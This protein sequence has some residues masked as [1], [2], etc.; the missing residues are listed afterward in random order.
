MLALSS[1]SLAVFVVLAIL[2]GIVAWVFVLARDSRRAAKQE[3]QRQTRML[4][5]D[6][7]AC[8]LAG[9]ELRRAKEVA[10]AAN[11]AKTR[12]LV[13]LSHEI[14]S[15]LNAI[16]GYA[17]LLER[18]SA[19]PATEAGSVIRRSAEHLT[20]LVDGLLEISRI[21][22][23]V[24]KL[25]S[26]VV[27]LQALLDHVVDMFRMQAAAKGLT[28]NYVVNGRLPRFV[29]TDEKRL[30]QIL[31]NLLSNAIKYTREGSATLSISYRSQMAEVDVVDTGI[32]IEPEDLERIFEPFERGNSPEAMSQPG[33]GLG[34]AITR[35]LARILGGEIF[36]SSAPG[37]GSHFR[38]RIFLPEP[39][40]APSGTAQYSRVIGYDGPRK[41]ILV[42]DDDPAQVTLLQS[43]L[44][45]LD[46]VVYWASQGVEGMMLADRCTP[47][48]VMLDIQIPGMS[49]W[50]VATRL[51]AMHGDALRI[52]MVSA[53][54]HEFRAGG[55][56][57]ASHDAF[58]SKPVD[59]K[60]LL[61]VIGRQLRL[62][63]QVAGENP[64]ADETPTIAPLPE[65]A[66]PFVERLRQQAKVGHVQAVEATLAEL[67]TEVPASISAVVAMR[68]HVRNF[69]LRSL[70]K[71]LDDVQAR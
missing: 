16:Y 17:Q 13:G 51:R 7:A 34:L 28:L 4:Q 29:R 59:F 53:N 40:T 30:R 20:N 54:A 19:I 68:A 47:D 21:E 26:D 62:T 44:R 6:I 38:L 66:A 43:L 37:V 35:V 60:A 18:E 24:T 45:P 10:E 9:A 70:M 12:Y 3:S 48:L 31:I 57:Y 56:E 36:A 52:V 2:A 8:T 33:I 23:G 22:S 42:V 15:P 50:E 41:T 64:N 1:K 69:D 67:E 32:G 61:D 49:G 39:M 71:M 65:S 25:S 11:A 5:E 27:P 46:F 63:W 55:D 14:R 58:V